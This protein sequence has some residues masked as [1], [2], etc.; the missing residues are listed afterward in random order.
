[1]KWFS[2]ALLLLLG[3]CALA[4]L[5]LPVQDVVIPVQGSLGNICYV[6]V[7]E[8]PPANFRRV[9]YQATATLVSEAAAPVTVRVYGRSSGPAPVFCLPPGGDE[10]ALS[11]SYRLEPNA[12]QAIIA[13]EGARAET[14]AGL[15]RGERYWLGLSLE[16]ETPFTVNELIRL[17]EGVIIASF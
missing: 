12:P 1:M 4:P 13:G 11:E 9:S 8:R 6:E 3:A 15:V 17:T 5:R 14:L 10:V 7:S 2:G 16:G